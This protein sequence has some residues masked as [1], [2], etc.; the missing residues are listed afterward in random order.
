MLD[1][2]TDF[3]GWTV[4]Y[5]E[6]GSEPGTEIRTTLTVV[7]A[8]PGTECEMCVQ[9]GGGKPARYTIDATSVLGI[10]GY[11]TSY[12]S[13]HMFQVVETLGPD[14]G[15]V[16]APPAPAYDPEHH[17]HHVVELRE[18]ADRLEVTHCWGVSAEEKD[19]RIKSLRAAAD[20]LEIHDATGL[21][22][23]QALNLAAFVEAVI[24]Q[25]IGGYGVKV[26]D[27]GA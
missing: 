1:D 20:L 9:V 23:T 12:C 17:R 22:L 26:Q 7:K 11:D 8:A 15:Q 25:G 5:D 10:G 13:P 19:L 3:T 27:N 21:N 6:G 4:T 16:W 14:S 2:N 18:E 24:E